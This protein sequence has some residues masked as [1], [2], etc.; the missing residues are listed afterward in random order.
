MH[1]PSQCTLSP[2]LLVVPYWDLI[3]HVNTYSAT[4]TGEQITRFEPE[5]VSKL[6]VLARAR[7]QLRWLL[8]VPWTLDT[9]RL[10]ALERS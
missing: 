4:L 9:F 1:C 3:E 6:N 8:L 5:S 2:F 10:L 7:S